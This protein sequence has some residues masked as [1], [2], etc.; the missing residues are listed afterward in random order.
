MAGKGAP[1]TGGRRK[2]TPNKLTTD[3]KEAILGQ[4]DAPQP[5]GLRAHR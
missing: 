4:A 1:K 3:L 2:G 5:L